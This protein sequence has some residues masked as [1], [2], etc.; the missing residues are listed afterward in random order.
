[1]NNYKD[2]LDAMQIYGD[3]LDTVH[4]G[5]I[6]KDGIEIKDFVRIAFW[7]DLEVVLIRQMPERKVSRTIAYSDIRSIHGVQLQ[8]RIFEHDEVDEDIFIKTKSSI[9]GHDEDMMKTIDNFSHIGMIIKK[10]ID[11]YGF[12]SVEG[13]KVRPT[14]SLYEKDWYIRLEEFISVCYKKSKCYEIGQMMGIKDGVASEWRMRLYN[15]VINFLNDKRVNEN[16]KEVLR[17]IIDKITPKRNL[18]TSLYNDMKKINRV[19]QNT[20]EINVLRELTFGV[21]KDDNCVFKPRVKFRDAYEH[22]I[23]LKLENE[24]YYEISNVTGVPVKTLYEWNQKT[25]NNVNY[26]RKNNSNEKIKI[27]CEK[28]CIK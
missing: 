24:A 16:D 9:I 25:K 8:S 23:D 18:K 27:F 13:N 4:V 21:Y 20:N 6:D 14:E 11:S 22:F 26:F 2:I 3:K 28:F 19:I 15:T 17:L 12:V 7:N 1:M 10:L 5:W